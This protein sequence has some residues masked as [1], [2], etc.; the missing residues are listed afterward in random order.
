MYFRCFAKPMGTVAA[1]IHNPENMNYKNA[2]LVIFSL[3]H[4]DLPVLR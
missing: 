2:I 1:C 3:E 4:F